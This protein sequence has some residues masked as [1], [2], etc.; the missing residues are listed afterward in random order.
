MRPLSLLTIGLALALTTAAPRGV[1]AQTLGDVLDAMRAGGGWVRIPVQGGR[2]NLTTVTM[3]AAGRNLE[4]CLEIWSGHTGAWSLRVEDTF[5]NGSLEVDA[6][7][8]QD[9]P[10]TYEPGPFARLA[11]DVEWSEPRDT[12]LLVW[13]G[14]TR[15]SAE[16]DPC[17]PVYPGSG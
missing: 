14:L 17:E 4:G 2:G 9:I 1:E 16:R 5:G 12:T 15:A 6:A 7:P 11:V 8:A 10:F 13:V 3:P